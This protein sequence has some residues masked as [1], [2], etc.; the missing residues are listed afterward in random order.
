MTEVRF[1]SGASKYLKKIKNKNLKLQFK[2]AFRC[3]AEKP[4]IGELK[5]GDLSGIYCYDFYFQRTCYEVAYMVYKKEEYIVVVILAGTR[6]NFYKSP[7]QL[8]KEKYSY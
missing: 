7:K 8:I 4:Y 6:E 2:E 5:Y 1:E 3:I